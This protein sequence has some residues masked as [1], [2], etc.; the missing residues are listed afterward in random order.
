MPGYI[1]RNRTKDLAASHAIVASVKAKLAQTD[2]VRDLAGRMRNGSPKGLPARASKA[3]P[4]THTAEG[5][6]EEI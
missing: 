3:A 1:A 2:A 4:V 5:L 6:N